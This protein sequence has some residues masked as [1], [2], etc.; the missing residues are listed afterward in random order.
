[1]KQKHLKQSGE[2][3][4]K[5]YR[6]RHNL[7]L[8]VLLSVLLI[9]LAYAID[10]EETGFKGV[11][12]VANTIDVHGVCKKVTN[13]NADDM[14]IPTNSTEEW[15]AFYTNADGVTIE[16]CCSNLYNNIHTDCDCV[17]AGG[18][19][20]TYLSKE[21]CYFATGAPSGWT[22][23]YSNYGPAST[24]SQPG[25]TDSATGDCG[26]QNIV[27]DP[28]SCTPGSGWSMAPPSCTF[29][30]R[31][32]NFYYGFV[33]YTYGTADCTAGYP[34]VPY[35]YPDA[36][37]SYCVGGFDTG[38]IGTPACVY[39]SGPDT[40]VWESYQVCK[41]LGIVEGTCLN[42]NPTGEELCY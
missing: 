17:A 2:D 38:N 35:D 19:V 3:K 7:L 27:L 25:D 26:T 16:N 14:F 33:K 6:W 8:L 21:L 11:V 10:T 23:L 20:Q 30:S 29:N 32:Q 1:M 5:G 18:N 34:T 31:I 36:E 28:D 42:T 39:I 41:W 40:P 22:A 15:E 24:C 12:G 37:C 13:T 9:T 4:E